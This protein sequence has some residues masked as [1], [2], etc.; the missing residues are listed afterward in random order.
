MRYNVFLAL[1]KLTNMC[2]NLKLDL[3]DVYKS[4]YILA[5]QSLPI[6]FSQFQLNLGGVTL[7]DSQT[8][9]AYLLVEVVELDPSNK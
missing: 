7:F 1:A 8:L 3:G 6:K 4:K 9:S 5:D 2:K